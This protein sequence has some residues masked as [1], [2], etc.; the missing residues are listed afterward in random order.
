MVPGC[1][2]LGIDALH[3]CDMHVAAPES[4]DM[5]KV[6]VKLDSFLKVRCDLLDVLWSELVGWW[7]EVD[8]QIPSSSA[9][10][11]HAASLP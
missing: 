8:N 2:N 4:Q 9:F 1:G 10:E 6:D 11:N 3:C 5:W 7:R